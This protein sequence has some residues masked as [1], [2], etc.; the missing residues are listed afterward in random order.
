MRAQSRISHVSFDQLL[1]EV[2]I[3]LL[4]CCYVRVTQ[5]TDQLD[6]DVGFVAVH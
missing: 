5:I 4:L 1:T 6:L 2:L 3:V